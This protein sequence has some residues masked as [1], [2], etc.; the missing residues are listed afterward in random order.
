MNQI[1]LLY[2][3]PS[4]ERK[5]I[6]KLFAGLE[7]EPGMIKVCLPCDLN[8]PRN[9]LRILWFSWQ[10]RGKYVHITGDVYFMALFLWRRKIV[11]T[12]HDGYHYDTLTGIKRWI[13]GRIWLD[14]P[15]RLAKRVVV[16]SETTQQYLQ[17]R[18]SVTADKLVVIPN[19]FQITAKKGPVEKEINPVFTILQIGTKDNKNLPRL[20]V[21]LKNLPVMLRIVGKPSQVQETQLR[22]A[23][24]NYSAVWDI[25]EEELMKEYQRADLLSFIST[26]E[27]FGLPILEAQYYGTPVL[28]AD[29]APMNVVAGEGALLADPFSVDDI[30]ARI[31]SL[32]H[33]E[34]IVSELVERGILNLDRFSY[35]RFKEAYSDVYKEVFGYTLSS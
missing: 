25:S 3:K 32:I 27:G 10:L 24:I 12:I 22:E 9:F 11:M 15:M 17:D 26:Q 18:F 33:G 35:K 19:Y 7:Q 23:G 6:E 2:R 4:P 14:L 28:T 8:T 20:I 29:K 34:V 1:L 5:S 13:Y 21:A 31:V 16:I 30:R